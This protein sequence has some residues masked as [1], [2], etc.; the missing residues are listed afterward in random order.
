MAPVA[1]V[2][3]SVVTDNNGSAPPASFLASDF[4][5]GALEAA[6]AGDAMGT[7]RLV[8]V[9]SGKLTPSVAF[10]MGYNYTSNPIKV[11]KES[12]GY[13]PDGFTALFN[14]NFNFT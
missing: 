14:L 7:Q 8:D 4:F 11:A 12:A 6:R 1:E 13:L 9:K 5:A 10:S 3:A 2:N